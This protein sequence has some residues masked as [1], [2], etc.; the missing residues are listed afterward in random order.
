MD[1]Y[2]VIGEKRSFKSSTIRSLSGC[3][4]FGARTYII[5]R[6]KP[7]SVFVYLSSLQ[8]GT[9]RTPKEFERLVEDT[10]ATACLFSLHPSGRGKFPDADD[11][12]SYFASI[13]WNIRRIAVLNSNTNP[14][15][16]TRLRTGV[17]QCFPF[18]RLPVA[19]NEL[20][21]NVRR[22]FGWL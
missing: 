17:L 15:T 5:G 9:G 20:A 1:A 13:G 21:A 19:V 8:E 4:V 18:L 2:V 22:H 7:T 3:R 12:L 16:N 10:N 6:D 11:Y 14:L